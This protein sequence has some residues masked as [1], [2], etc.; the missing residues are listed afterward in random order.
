MINFRAL[1]VFPEGF[2]QL[3]FVLQVSQHPQPTVWTLYRTTVLLTGSSPCRPSQRWTYP[4]APQS[5]LNLRTI[6]PS[7]PRCP[8]T[9]PVGHPTFRWVP[10]APPVSFTLPRQVSRQHSEPQLSPPQTCY[11]LP[12]W[13]VTRDRVMN[14]LPLLQENPIRTANENT[15]LL[16]K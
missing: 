6:H 8:F 7:V 15:I 16:T 5:P 4:P 11:R 12:A 9:E 10:P 2:I 13:T 3:L 1:L 14:P